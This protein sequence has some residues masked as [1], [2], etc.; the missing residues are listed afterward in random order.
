MLSPQNYDSTVSDIPRFINKNP[1]LITGKTRRDKLW[2][3]GGLY[4]THGKLNIVLGFQPAKEGLEDPVMGMTIAH[5]DTLDG[6][7]KR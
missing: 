3:Y 7:P 2:Q 1:S 6:I 5:D 4:I